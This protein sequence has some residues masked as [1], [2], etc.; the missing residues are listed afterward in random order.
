MCGIAGS[1][2]HRDAPPVV[3]ARGRRMLDLIAHRGPDGSGTWRDER[4]PAWLGHRRLAIIDLA[5][6]AQPMR[7]VDGR[8]TVTFNGCIYNYRELRDEL[9]SR[10]H[11]FESQSDTEVILHAFAQWGDECVK[12]F[13]GM[14]A[15]AIWDRD[16]RRVFCARDRLGIKPFYWHFD[17]GRLLFASE[18]KALFADRHVRRAVDRDGLRQYL[19]LQ[20]C[21]HDRTMFQGVR[22]LPPGCSLS[23]ALGDPAPVVKVWW[24]LSFTI[25]EDHSESWFVR[26][27]RELL[28]DSVRLRLRS[29]VPLGAHLSGGTDSSVVVALARRLLPEGSPLSTFTGAFELGARYD[30]RRYSRLMAERAHAEP[31]EIVLGAHDF[32]DS[33]AKIAW[34][35]DE[36]AA[37][38]GVFPQFH[39]SR[40][41]RKHVKVVLGGQGG[42][43]LF[44][45]YARYLVAYLEECLKGAI[46]DTAQR[47]GYVATLSTIVP[48]LPSL[49]NYLPMLR[50]FWKRGAFGE[51]ARRY[52]D[53]M[54]RFGGVAGLLS[55]DLRIDGEQTFAE[56]RSI[57]EVHGAASMINRIL[58]FDLKTHLQS[59]LHVEDRTSMAFGLESR[60][61]LLDYR[62]VEL[63]AS[64]RPRL[65][66]QNGHLKHLFLAAVGDLL[67]EPIRD[68]RD[69]MGFPVP[70]TEWGRGPLRPMLHDIL[71]S[72][73]ARERGIFEPTKLLAAVDDEAAFGRTAWGALC[74]ESWLCQLVDG[75]GFPAGF[76]PV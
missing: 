16:A 55:G 31:H 6:G 59:L 13:N 25:D 74:I 40:L 62:L 29:D 11:R 35:M 23:F 5:G 44:I 18:I 12:H 15:F 75:D 34:H 7:T 57:F 53:L 66:F 27:L 17:D 54:D 37:G 21:L 19:A 52:F 24:D 26:R 22:R 56:F 43:E 20:F 9:E 39:V 71:G 65:K 60:V 61:P 42:D 46:E 76:E 41:A 72:R 14:W 51:P 50:A 68:R 3:E 70:L 69:K 64:V 49:Q 45:G 30:E 33:I 58:Y 8:L 36:P 4:S 1:I 38:P 73:R 10:G 2:G 67:P 28:E 63:M 48:N 32:E 47:E